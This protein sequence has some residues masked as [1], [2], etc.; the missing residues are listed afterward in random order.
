MPTTHLSANLQL[1]CSYKASI[2]E[3]ARALSLNRSQL[4]KYLSGTSQPRPGLM[5]RIGDHFGLEVHE[6]LMPASDFAELLRV[7]KPDTGQRTR[8]IALNFEK[9]M[10]HSDT[11]L[12]ALEGNYYEYYQS[13]SSPGSV[14]CSLV[15][16][17]IHDDIV[18]YQRIERIDAGKP[19][20]HKRFNYRGVALMLGERIFMTDFE[21]NY[22][23]ELTQTVLYP[24]Y[25]KSNAKLFGIK[26]GV[27]AN[28]QRMPCAVRV[29]LE[30][31]PP[32]STLRT[33]LR[34]CGLYPTDSTALPSHVFAA[35]DNRQSDSQHFQA[36]LDS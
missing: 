35:I 25:T 13:M 22:Q 26:V 9:L 10:S 6:L 4:N 18:Y 15:L 5:R 7:R 3:V 27:S 19:P 36:Y 12:K 1:L 32:N 34:R 23:I 14:L 30:R 17:D 16:F 21:Q 24:D 33:Q 31:V 8:Q 20:S 29:L 11:R 2:A 28:R